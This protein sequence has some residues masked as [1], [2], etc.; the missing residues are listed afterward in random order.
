MT[1]LA[2]L[3][4]AGATKY[5]KR[6]GLGTSASPFTDVLEGA[7]NIDSSLNTSSATTIGDYKQL[8][9]KD[10]VLID[11]VVNGT[12]TATFNTTNNG[13][14]MAVS[15]NADYIIR[16][17]K[18]FHNYTAGNPQRVEITCIDITPVANIIKRFGYYS[19]SSTAPYTASLDGMCLETDDTN[20]YLKIYK[21]GTAVFSAVQ[22]SWDDPMDGS[23][24]SGLTLTKA[25]FHVMV[26]DF[27]YLGGTCARFGFVINDSVT[28]VHVFSNSNNNAS[29]FVASPNQ[30]LRWEIRSSGGS[31]SFH[32]ICGKVATVGVLKGDGIT[33]SHSLGADHIN[34][35]T[36]GTKYALIGV[37]PNS[38]LIT[39]NVSSL[40]A[41]ALTADAFL[42]EL[43]LNA[44]V[45]G[46]FTYSP[47]TDTDY[48]IA[49]GS[50]DGSNT[51]STGT[52]LGGMY[53]S[54]SGG[55]QLDIDNILRPGCT[56]PGVFEDLVL[57]VTPLGANLDILGNINVTVQP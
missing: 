12:A 38:R 19:S 23:G 34:A 39:L 1:N 7:F 6:N 28:W 49:I 33:R 57:C 37:K 47:V 22:S 14:D 54:S 44:T 10:D 42:L 53:I 50:T 56:I 17:T 3:D 55:A 52:V 32:Q 24:R 35:N 4:G 48:D 26:I 16:Q 30:P 27:L 18:N 29:T 46:T 21:S 5:L 43:V 8:T 2:I 45:A 25:S 9:G 31:T 36:I 11:E 13:V 20:V 41:V 40:T 15:A 51:I